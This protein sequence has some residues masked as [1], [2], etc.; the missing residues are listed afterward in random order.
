MK[1][2]Y[3]AYTLQLS[4]LFLAATLF[5]KANPALSQA[6]NIVP[7]NTLGEESS[8]VIKNQNVNGLPTEV[9]TGGAQREQNLFHSFQEFNVSEGRGAYFNSPNVDIQN[10]FSRVTGSNPSEIMGVLGT[11]G[12]SNPD[13]YLINPNRIIFGENSSLDVGGSFTATTA[14]AIEFGEGGLFSA[15]APLKRLK[16]EILL[17]MSPKTLSLTIV[18]LAVKFQ[19]L[20]IRE[21]SIL[22]LI[23]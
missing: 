16:Q 12:E 13:L 7:D 11:F 22:I 14:D 15:V 20:A 18:V 10:I 4:P 1:L 3:L 21:I 19:V 5:S 9:I 23:L 2:V 17:L 8:Q 6:S